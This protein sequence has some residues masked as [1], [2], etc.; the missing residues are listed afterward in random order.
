MP[1]V[2]DVE[3]GNDVSEEVDRLVLSI[4]RLIGRQMARDDHAASIPAN[5]NGEHRAHGQEP[6][7]E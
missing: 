5:D 3:T 1:T 6:D 7:T 2:D 4:A